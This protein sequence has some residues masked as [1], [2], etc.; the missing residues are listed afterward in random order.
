[1]T[2][3]AAHYALCNFCKEPFNRRPAANHAADITV[4]ITGYMVEIQYE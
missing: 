1:M 3:G 4:L 2:I